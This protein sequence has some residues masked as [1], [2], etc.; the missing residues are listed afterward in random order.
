MFFGFSK[1]EQVSFSVFLEIFEKNLKSIRDIEIS[2]MLFL[3]NK[4]KA[5]DAANYNHKYAKMLQENE[6]MWIQF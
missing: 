3:E 5:T 6:N 1:V 2:V 4:L